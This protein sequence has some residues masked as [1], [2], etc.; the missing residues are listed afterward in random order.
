MVCMKVSTLILVFVLCLV[1]SGQANPG[2][3]L[4]PSNQTCYTWEELEDYDRYTATGNGNSTSLE[5]YWC[6]DSWNFYGADPPPTSKTVPGLDNFE[7]GGL[8]AF[9]SGFDNAWEIAGT[10]ASVSELH[11]PHRD[12]YHL[13]L[14]GNGE[15]TNAIGLSGQTNA[16]LTFWWKA[17]DLEENDYAFV[18]VN[19]GMGWDTLATI[20]SDQADGVYDSVSVP[21]STY[22]PNS[23]G[24]K[25]G[26]SG[27]SGDEDYVAVDDVAFWVDFQGT[28][29]PTLTE[30]GM[31]I[32]CALLFAW[33]AWVLARR[34]KRITIGT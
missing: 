34:R 6:A 1:V 31:I 11:G 25:F 12:F 30:W 32:F 15:A 26:V 29:V 8:F 19:Y 21:L 24:F 20:T 7:T 5:G 27:D 23:M 3:W 33:M 14:Q 28:E 4:S 16:E 22:R 18:A 13:V 2:V 17:W 9:G 10:G